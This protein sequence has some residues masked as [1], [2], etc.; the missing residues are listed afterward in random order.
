M[1][2]EGEDERDALSVRMVAVSAAFDRKAVVHWHS[3]PGRVTARMDALVLREE[4]GVGFLV[5]RLDFE[6]GCDEVASLIDDPWADL[7]EPYRAA[8][9]VTEL[10]RQGALTEAER[11]FHMAFAGGLVDRAL[12]GVA[13]CRGQPG[14]QG[15]A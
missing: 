2:L 3:V 9:H 6:G 5:E 15:A 12:A 7:V 8:G 4:Q 11:A 14:T 1:R 10:S 13:T